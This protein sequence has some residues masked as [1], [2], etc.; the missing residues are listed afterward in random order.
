MDLKA[1]MV[2]GDT[3]FGWLRQ[4]T[5]ASPGEPTTNLPVQ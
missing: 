2:E 4:T 1:T 5:A 3:Q